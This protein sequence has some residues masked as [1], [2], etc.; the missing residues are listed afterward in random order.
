MGELLKFLLQSVMFFINPLFLIP[1]IIIIVI[2]VIK[3]R[4]YKKGAYY[5]VTKRPYLSVKYDTGRYGEYLTYKYLK[6][7]EENGA[8]FLF[9]IY[10]PKENGETSEI[11]VLMISKKGLFVFESKNYSGWI[12]GSEN[13]KNWCQILPAGRGRSYKERFYSPIM[14]NRS[15]IKHLKAFLGEQIP[16]RSIIVFSDRCTLKSGQ[17]RSVDISVINRYDVLPVVC[18]ICNMFPDDLLTDSDITDIYNRLYPYTQVG[19]AVKTQHVTN[20]H[21]SLNP[22]PIQPVIDIPVQVTQQSQPEMNTEQPDMTAA[23]IPIAA[24]EVS[25]AAAAEPE[26]AAAGQQELKCPKC[27]GDLILRTAARGENSGKQ[28]YGCSNYPK[29]KY[30]RN[31]TY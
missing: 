30:I 6:R 23:D 11:D 13:Q 27:N 20:I 10:I 28:F 25:A 18:N 15:H 29:C 26:A 24:D 21:N 3:N 16:M 1:V 5:Q 8:K 2:L 31:I 22:P 19:E 4:E 17:M 12:F 14:Q 7:F 9:N